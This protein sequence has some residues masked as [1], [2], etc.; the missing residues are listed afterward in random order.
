MPNEFDQHRPMPPVARGAKRVARVAWRVALGAWRMAQSAWRVACAMVARRWPT[1]A[2]IDDSGPESAKSARPRSG[3]PIEQRSVS[4]HGFHHNSA[5]RTIQRRPPCTRR[6]GAGD[7]E[8]GSLPKARAQRARL[9]CAAKLGLCWGPASG[10]SLS[11]A[12]AVNASAPPGDV[13]PSAPRP[14]LRGPR[15]SRPGHDLWTRGRPRPP[16]PQMPA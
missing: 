14:H 3:T 8:A 7:L 5:A 2:E 6:K 10:A 9:G 13:R 4:A 15:R 16:H 11:A 12:V 1:S